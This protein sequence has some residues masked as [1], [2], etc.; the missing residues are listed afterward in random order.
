MLPL[1]AEHGIAYVPFG[2]LAGG[3]LAGKYA[4]GAGFP[5]GSRM[6]MRPEPY[7]HLVAD[8]VFDGLDRARRRGGGARRRRWRR[9]RSPGCSRIRTSP[10]A[11]CGPSRP[12]HLEPVLAALDVPLSP[13]E[14]DRIG[15]FFA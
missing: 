12:E 7:E 8:R 3:W 11:V 6:T 2:P 15:S 14:R 4:R 9:S 5:E 1:C 13:A 10:A